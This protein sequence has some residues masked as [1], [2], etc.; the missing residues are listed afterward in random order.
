MLHPDEHPNMALLH[1][2]IALEKGI[3]KM[4]VLPQD[5]AFSIKPSEISVPLWDIPTSLATA[6]KPS[7]LL[8][9]LPRGDCNARPYDSMDIAV[10]FTSAV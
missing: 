7:L 5:R 2:N 9:G 6:E 3:L 4:E 1:P 8:E 10:F